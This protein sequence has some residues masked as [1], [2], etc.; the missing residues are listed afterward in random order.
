MLTLVQSEDELIGRIA[1][2]LSKLKYQDQAAE[3][4]RKAGDRGHRTADSLFA[5]WRRQGAGA[6]VRH[7]PQLGAV[8]GDCAA[9]P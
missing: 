1:Y 7:V 2:W 8:A 5:D 6:A 4:L 9:P 3:M